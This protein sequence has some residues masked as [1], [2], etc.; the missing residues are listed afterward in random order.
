MLV[1]VTSVI[2]ALWIL[3]FPVFFLHR[4]AR[5][6]AGVD[7]EKGLLEKYAALIFS[8]PIFSKYPHPAIRNRYVKYIGVWVLVSMLLEAI[9]GLVKH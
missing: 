8:A 7:V 1:G 3:G 9:V 4:T 2:A 5:L 6:L